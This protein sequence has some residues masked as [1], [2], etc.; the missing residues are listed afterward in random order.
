MND[1]T[2][3]T[4]HAVPVADAAQPLRAFVEKAT[5]NYFDR[6]HGETP[7]DVYELIN[8]EMEAGLLT[9]VMKFT[10]GNQ[11]R[12]AVLLGLSRGTL[13]KKLKKYGYL[14]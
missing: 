10:R 12:A 5:Q 13:R 3:E 4:L 11:S 7:K 9:I 1:T 6:L 2:I 8:S 14:D